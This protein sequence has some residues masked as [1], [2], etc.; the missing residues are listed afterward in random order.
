MSSLFRITIIVLTLCVI[1]GCAGNNYPDNVNNSLKAA[2]DNKAELEQVIT[3]YQTTGDSLKLEAAYFLIGNMEEHCYVTYRLFDTSDATVEFDPMSFPDYKALLVAIDSIESDRGELDYGK[4]DKIMDVE[5]IKADFLINHI[6]LAFRAW[7]DK[8]WAKNLTFKNFCRY[9]LP[10][11]GSNEPL[12]DWRSYF[13]EKYNDIDDKLDDD[14]DPVN[15]ASVINDD[16]RAWFGF[17]ERYYFH[18][19]DQGLSEMLDSKLGRCEDMTNITIFALRANGLAVTSDYTPHWANTG[20][21]HAWNAILTEDGTVIP[22]MGAEANP[23]HYRLHNKAAK[24]YRKTYDQQPD[25]LVF[26]PNKQEK[27][28]RWLAGKY[29]IDVTNDYMDAID[30]VIDVTES[31]P[32]SIDIAYICVFNSGKFR[33]INWGRIEDGKVTFAD[34]GTGILY[35]AA[36]YQNKEVVT[37]GEPFVLEDNGVISY[38]SISPDTHTS[39]SIDN[40]PMRAMATSTETVKHTPL[41]SGVTYELKYW[42]GSEWTEFSTYTPKSKTISV[43]DLPAGGLYWLTAQDSKNDERIFTIEANKQIFW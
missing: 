22:F 3:H 27:M 23:G 4:L 19:T 39:L 18:P 20:N 26:Q 14:K 43:S 2:G 42:H 37:F 16:V 1:A 34:M 8:P 6:D 21:N 31:I 11:R 24:V 10:Y 5:V 7:K 30:A 36:T 38:K 13:M 9:V 25:N 35:I 29:Y 12:E 17:D 15:V 33:P 32:D 40:I 28:P 41:A